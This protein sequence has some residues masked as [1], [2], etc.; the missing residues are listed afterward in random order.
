[1]KLTFFGGTKSV[2][3][4]CYLLETKKTRVLVDCGLR[5]GC[6]VCGEFNAK[7]FPF[8]PS[9]IDAVFV[10]HAHADHLG[11]IP[12]L[13]KEGFKGSIF[14]TAPTK[15][16]AKIAFADSERVI[17][18]EAQEKGIQPLY[19][20]Q[21]VKTSLSLW[22]TVSYRN[23]F[24]LGDMRVEFFNA[25]H[26]L[27]SSSILIQGDGKRIA[28]SGDLGNKF[29]PFILPADPIQEADYA[30][31]ESAYGGRRHEIKQIGRDFLEDVVES[32]VKKKGTLLI[33]SFALERTQQ[34][35]FD[36]NALVENKRIPQIPVFLDSPLA[37]KLTGVYKKYSQDKDFFKESA[38][39]LIHGGDAIFNFP[40]LEL[41]Q[42]SY[43]SRKIDKVDPPKIIIAGS[44]MSEGGRIL[45]HE[46]RYLPDPS[47]TILFVGFQVQGSLGRE[48]L[49][50][51][52]EATIMEE[53]V[54]IRAEVSSVQAYSAHADQIGL[55]EWVYPM[56][57]S[58]K[59]A[60]VV[61]GEEDQAESLS[62]KIRDEFAVSAEVPSYGDSVVL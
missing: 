57:L 31:V 44:G 61:Q 51:A 41:T 23:E 9:S 30:L 52:G 59:K 50:G 48:I 7:P 53:K 32:L 36:L 5:Q 46:K 39:R 58:L 56:R 6:D 25:G 14:S 54:R 37:I 10:T 43:Q 38:I 22:K 12:K 3:G 15:D 18:Y 21:D 13:V 60:F 20:S 40:G 1:M 27:G 49:E 33:P 24:A 55:L 28:F 42:T 11:R 8:K 29:T 34:M 17:R 26:V 4:A 35:L 45:R 62:H 16:L 19:D 2:T 47:T